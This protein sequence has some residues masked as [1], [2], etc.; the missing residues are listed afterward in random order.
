MES[1]PQVTVHPVFPLA[2]WQMT[3]LEQNNMQQG[4][5]G[6]GSEQTLLRI[7]CAEASPAG[8]CASFVGKI[9]AALIK[10]SHLRRSLNTGS[11]SPFRC[12]I[13]G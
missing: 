13:F 4:W 3:Q 7:T 12:K 9:T 10:M 8:F 1:H 6:K 11:G 2:H 5:D